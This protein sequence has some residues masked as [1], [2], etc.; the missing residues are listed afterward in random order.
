MPASD[1]PVVI[2][3]KAATV[4]RYRIL[5]HDGHPDAALDER[6]WR[7]FADPPLATIATAE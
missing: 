4:F 6:A 7:D 1:K 2:G 5:I 3:P